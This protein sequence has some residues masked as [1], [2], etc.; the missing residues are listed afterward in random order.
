MK[1]SELYSKTFTS[2]G[3]EINLIHEIVVDLHIN[4]SETLRISCTPDLFRE[5]AVG[6]A[7]TE[8]Y[9]HSIEDIIRIDC[10]ENERFISIDTDISKSP[11]QATIQNASIGESGLKEVFNESR[12]RSIFREFSKTPHLHELTGAAHSCMIVKADPK[13]DE[14][15]EILFRSEDAGRHSALDKAI[16]WA[17]MNGVCLSEC[18]LVTSG[19]ISTRMAEKSA[20]AGVGALAGKGTVTAEAK[21]IAEDSGMDLMAYLR[22]D[23]GTWII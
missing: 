3:E 12:I 7:F 23:G 5:L 4:K 6:Y 21:R 17:L 18:F 1:T 15:V 20:R 11:R 10:R 9:I 13:N 16:G 22:G 14:E 2:L 8:G 19:R